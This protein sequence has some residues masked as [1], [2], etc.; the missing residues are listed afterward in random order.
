M[1]PRRS[2]AA[3]SPG[4]TPDGEARLEE[5]QKEFRGL[6]ESQAVLSARRRGAKGVDNADVDGSYGYLLKPRDRPA[7]IDIAAEIGLFV[8]GG[9]AGYSTSLLTA[10]PPSYTQ[11]GVILGTGLLFAILCAIIKHV[12]IG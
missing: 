2:A 11:G 7:I 8:C 10:T 1:S 3:N 12:E 5:N 4:F 6:L 9:L